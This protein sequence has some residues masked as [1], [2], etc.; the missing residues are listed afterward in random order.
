M[1][2]QAP[3]DYAVG[4]DDAIHNLPAQSTSSPLDMFGQIAASIRFMVESF[5]GQVAIAFGGISIFGWKPFDFLAQWGQDRIDEASA[6]YLAATSAQAAAN[7]ANTNANNALTY[8]GTLINDLLTVPATVIGNLPQ[9]LVS[10]LVAALDAAAATAGTVVNVIDGIVNGFLGLFGVGW[11]VADA[12]AAAAAI[13]EQQAATAAGVAALQ[14]QSNTA[15][16][17]GAS[18]FVDFSTFADATSLGAAFAQFYSGAG[19]NTWGITSGRVSVIAP[20]G[21]TGGRVARAVYTALDTLTDYQRVSAVFSSSQMVTQYGF[22][23]SPFFAY[24]FNYIDGRSDATGANCVRVIFGNGTL[25]FGAVIGGVWTQWTT[26]A[27]AFR[28]GAIYSLECGTI[29]GIRQYKVLCNSVPILVWT[30]VGTASLLGASYRKSGL[31]AEWQL[32]ID[33]AGVPWY[34]GPGGVAAFAV[35]DSTLPTLIGSIGRA[36]RGS[37]TSGLVGVAGT[38]YVPVPNGLFDTIEYASTDLSFN[39]TTG[40]WTVTKRGNYLISAQMQC[41]ITNQM[42][43]VNVMVNG[44]LRAGGG[45][46]VAAAGSFLTALSPGDYVQIVF[47]AYTNLDIIGAAV[48]N[49]TWFQIARITED[50][51]L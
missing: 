37:S 6:N 8:I 20:S 51:V 45:S 27:H 29:G 3:P 12:Q 43:I 1:S 39:T 15:A 11:G 33:G 23:F 50:V 34:A 40:T 41:A 9:A 7:T 49:V 35:A 31:G 44:I 24:G 48:G 38:S 10:G 5:I 21:I 4:V 14:Q 18:A 32:G 2:L 17:S 25:W 22:P 42:G 47:K 26:Q 19:T 16:Q 36:Y 30:E 46:G 28:P 13:A